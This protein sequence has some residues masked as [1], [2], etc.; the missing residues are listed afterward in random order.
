M[1]WRDPDDEDPIPFIVTEAERCL[2]RL[3]NAARAKTAAVQ[4]ELNH[5]K[6]EISTLRAETDREN[7]SLRIENSAL[8]QRDQELCEYLGAASGAP[9]PADIEVPAE[10]QVSSRWRARN[11]TAA[12]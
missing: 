5:A 9:D 10:Q 1:T 12:E 11:R 2:L 4:V 6:A 7:Q 3:L 8:R